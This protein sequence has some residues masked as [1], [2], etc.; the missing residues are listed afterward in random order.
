MLKFD[1]AQLLSALNKYALGP[2]DLPLKIANAI[3]SENGD[4]LKFLIMSHQAYIEDSKFY[5]SQSYESGFGYCHE[6]VKEKFK[7]DAIFFDCG[8]ISSVAEWVILSDAI[9]IGGYALLHDIY[10]PKSIKNFLVATYIELSSD[11]EI[12]YRNSVSP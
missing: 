11:W 8:E 10:Y 7:A 1:R 3:C 5:K 4:D 12:I 2:I 9:S 6:L